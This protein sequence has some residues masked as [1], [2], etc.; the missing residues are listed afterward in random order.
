MSERG[1]QWAVVVMIEGGEF[2][3]LIRSGYGSYNTH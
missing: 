3:S 1:K 2:S